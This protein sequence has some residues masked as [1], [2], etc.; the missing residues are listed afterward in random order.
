[1]LPPTFL[2]NLPALASSITASP[3]TPATL[4]IARRKRTADQQVPACQIWSI[5]YKLDRASSAFT[6]RP[7][8]HFGDYDAPSGKGLDIEL[9]GDNS[10]SKR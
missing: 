4:I 6:R 8:R 9:F 1:M 10:S 2:L 7:N 3:T 5:K